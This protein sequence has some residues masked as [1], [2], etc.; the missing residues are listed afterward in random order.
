M[1]K[2]D[3]RRSGILNPNDQQIA[4]ELFDHTL[5][6][7]RRVE[8]REGEEVTITTVTCHRVHGSSM[9][10]YRDTHDI[11]QMT[12]RFRRG[13]EFWHDDGAE[14]HVGVFDD[15]SKVGPDL[16]HP[17]AEM[18]DRILREIHDIFVS[19]PNTPNSP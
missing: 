8:I 14:G 5:N 3:L 19:V 4:Q 15:L 11:G 12:V 10:L 7:G 16:I 17:D 13:R 9:E 6:N 1:E 18:R 2:D